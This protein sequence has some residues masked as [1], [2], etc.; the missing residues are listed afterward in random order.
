MCVRACQSP[1]WVNLW[2]VLCNDDAIDLVVD[3]MKVR[4]CCLFVE[5][6]VVIHS[7]TVVF[8]GQVPPFLIESLERMGA[9]NEDKDVER[10]CRHTL[11][12]PLCCK[13]VSG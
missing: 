2:T 13:S 1:G 7:N 10:E 3:H 9:S 8:I 6:Q 5:A 4:I 12:F 11:I